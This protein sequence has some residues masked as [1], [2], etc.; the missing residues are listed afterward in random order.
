MDEVLQ[1]NQQAFFSASFVEQ[2]NTKVYMKNN[3]AFIAH[4]LGESLHIMSN[5][6][7]Y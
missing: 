2:G 5:I 1:L 6:S 4:I 3:H 7:E